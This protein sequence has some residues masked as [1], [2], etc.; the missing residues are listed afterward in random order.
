MLLEDTI[1]LFLDSV[2][3]SDEY[4]FYLKK[5]RSD[6]AR[7]FAVLVPD[8]ESLE[9]AASALSFQLKFLR[10]LELVPLQVYTGPLANRMLSA[11]RN[12]GDDPVVSECALSEIAGKGAELLS[13]ARSSDRSAVLMV[14]DAPLVAVLRALSDTFSRRFHFIRLRGPLHDV[15]GRPLSYFHLRGEN[16][17]IAG[18]DGSLLDA[19]G[20]CAESPG[21]HVSVS[22]PI[23]LLREIFTVKGAGTIFRKGSL[24]AYAP[25]SL[26]V[27]RARMSGLLETSFGRPLRRPDFLE[28]IQHFHY[29]KD[30][31]GAVLLEDRPEGAYLSKFAVGTEARGEGIAQELWEAV[32]LRHPSLFWRS[33]AGSSVNRWYSRISDGSHKVPGWQIFWRGVH[34]GQIPAVIDFCLNKEEDFVPRKGT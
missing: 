23:N 31:T 11:Y 32:R 30:Y 8:L 13:Q 2:G 12:G 6:P 20:A 4:E 21:R 7:A 18:R 14:Q 28:K 19:A 22:T 25:S 24:I 33:R 34:P 3:R 17:Q 16:P 27:D 9:N 5:F 10:R 29:E 26:E 15:E 1:R